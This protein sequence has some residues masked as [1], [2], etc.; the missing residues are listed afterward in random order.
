M[1]SQPNAALA[2]ALVLQL[3]AVLSTIDGLYIHLWRLRLHGRPESY[4]EHLLHTARTVLFVPVVVTVFA[5]PSA[6]FLLWVG[7]AFAALDQA[8]GIV[9]ALAERDSRASLGGLG[10]SE[11]AL[12]VALVEVHAIALTLGLVARPSEAW[13]L[14]A[15]STLGE[16]PAAVQMLVMGPI[17]GGIAVAALHVVLAWANR[18]SFACC[19]AKAA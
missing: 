6:G 4:R 1:V 17:V 9:D 12:H 18:P 13:S 8:A 5:M 3:F 16:W 15:P 19:A 10:R 11:Y 2:A 7:V 14:S